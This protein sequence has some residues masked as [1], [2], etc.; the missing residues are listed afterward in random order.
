MIADRTEDT[1]PA[2]G[3][4]PLEYRFVADPMAIFLAHQDRW[5]KRRWG[6]PSNMRPQ[7]AADLGW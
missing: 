4:R 3:G 2:A 6:V 5:S 1:E 7:A